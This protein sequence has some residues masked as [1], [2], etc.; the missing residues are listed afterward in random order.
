MEEATSLMLKSWRTNTNR[1]CKQSWLAR[2]TH[3]QWLYLRTLAAR[4]VE[5]S[6]QVAHQRLEADDTLADRT[7][8]NINDIMSLL[9]L[10]LNATFFSYR[11]VFYQQVFGTAMGSPVSVIVANLV[12]EEVEDRALASFPSPPRSWKR[13]VDDICS[14][15]PRSQAST[16]LQ[17]LNSVEP[18]IQFTH[19]VEDNDH[20][21][22]L[23]DILLT[24]RGE[25]VYTSVYR[26]PTHTDRYIDF[27]SHHPL[28]HKA[29]VVKTLIKRAEVISSSPALLEEECTRICQSLSINNYPHGFVCRRS[30]SKPSCQV[31]S[32]HRHKPFVVIPYVR[33]LSEAIKRLLS[34]VDIRVLHRPHTTLHHE[35]VHPKDP[36]PIAEKSGVVYS[37]PCSTCN[38]VYI[39]QTGWRL[40]TRLK[41]HKV[42]VKFA[43]TEIS[44]VAEHVWLKLIFS[45]PPFWPKNKIVK[46]A[47]SW[48]LGTYKHRGA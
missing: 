30:Q 10:C 42:A 17:H 48:S 25:S 24:R 5:D 27:T 9:S 22:P 13:Y 43:K 39:G 34:C 33:G 37:I 16:L 40:E 46:S 12:M 29:A 45:Q 21:L 18:S 38:E 2:K 44:A 4:L 28:V 3:D 35:L 15:V 6:L 26:K 47:A 14:I 41:E 32:E 20:S 11:G 19:E 1:S 8:L 36:S 31:S 7:T 23:L